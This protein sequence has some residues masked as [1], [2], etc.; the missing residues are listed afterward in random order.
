MKYFILLKDKS[1]SQFFSKFYLE[2]Y[3]HAISFF[4]L[5]KRIKFGRYLVYILKNLFRILKLI[6]V[7][8]NT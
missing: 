3:F 6:C 5:N 1:R 8:E 4:F 7:K 2:N